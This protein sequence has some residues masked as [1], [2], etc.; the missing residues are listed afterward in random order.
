MT[1]AQTSALQ[2]LFDKHTP[3]PWSVGFW[4]SDP[5]DKESKMRYVYAPKIKPLGSKDYFEI[6]TC[7]TGDVSDE[8][9]E[10]N[11]NLIAA[12]PELLEALEYLVSQCDDDDF[13]D[14]I[15]NDSYPERETN[16]LKIARAAIAKARG[17]S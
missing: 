13:Y 9:E 8:Q 12:A 3:G 6:A 5:A 14:G 1:N 10:A 16:P 11:S 15:V 2:P 7:C 4:L 17:Q